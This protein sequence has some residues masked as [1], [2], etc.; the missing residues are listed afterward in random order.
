[1]WSTQFLETAQSFRPALVNGWGF[2]LVALAPGELP[3]GID[4]VALLELFSN[5]PKGG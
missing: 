1:M 2:F 3:G 4:R 5:N